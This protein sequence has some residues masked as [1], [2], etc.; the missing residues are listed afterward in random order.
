MAD[1][2]KIEKHS[3]RE[4]FYYRR[5]FLNRVHEALTT[6]FEEECE[7]RDWTRQDVAERID[8]DPAQISRWLSA[9]SNLTLESISDLLLSVDAEMDVN[10]ARFGERKTPNYMHPLI[11]GVLRR[12]NSTR[13]TVS[14]ADRPTT[15]TSSPS[16]SEYTVQVRVLENAQ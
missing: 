10:I 13:T 15:D 11:A 2:S 6:F 3:E 9:P 12:K 14:F 7:R 4:I 8:R 5:R 16:H 1:T